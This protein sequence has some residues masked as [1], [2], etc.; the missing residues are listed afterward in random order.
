MIRR[1]APRIGRP[2]DR[3]ILA[4]ATGYSLVE[5]MAVMV[6]AMI[7]ITMA[8]RL[9]GPGL[10]RGKV[11]SAANLVASDLQYAQVMAVR[12]RHPVAIIVNTSLR[13]YLI[14]DRDDATIVFRTRNLGEDSAYD[15]ETLSASPTTNEVFPNGIARTSM[16]FTLTIQD[17]SRTVRFTRAGQVRVV[18][19]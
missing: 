7:L 12:S 1:T 9:L 18:R 16:E 8:F 3:S 4:A 13:Q 5:M 17:Y 19:P 6:V 2:A 15:I 11:N 10:I 14:R